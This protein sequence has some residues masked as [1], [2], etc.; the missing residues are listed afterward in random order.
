M[1]KLRLLVIGSHLRSPESAWTHGYLFCLLSYN[2]T[3]DYFMLL[4]NCSSLGRWELLSLAAV[5]FWRTPWIGF[6]FILITSLLSCITRC[7]SLIL[8]ISC[9]RLRIYYFTKKPWFLLWEKVFKTKIWALSVF[10]AAGVVSSQLSQLT[11]QG[12]M[13]ACTLTHI[14]VYI[15]THIYKHSICDHLHLY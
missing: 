5:S 8:C 2:P 6:C 1:I 9:P 10:L 13:C 3:L 4:A 14:C 12:K 11:E 15:Y 7:S